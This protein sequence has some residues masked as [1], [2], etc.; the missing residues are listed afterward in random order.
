LLK[1]SGRGHLNLLDELAFISVSKLLQEALLHD[2]GEDWRAALCQRGNAV[3][4]RAGT[5]TDVVFAELW[6]AQVAAQ[7]G[8]VLARWPQKAHSLRAAIRCAR[9]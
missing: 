2:V 3:I 9:A 5:R 1:I 7:H 4:R 6:F 8:N